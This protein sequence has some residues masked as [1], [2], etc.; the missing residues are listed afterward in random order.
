MHV[1]VNDVPDWSVGQR[2][3]VIN[4]FGADFC[5]T[6]RVDHRDRLVANDETRVANVATVTWRVNRVRTLVNEYAWSDLLRFCILRFC[7]LRFCP[8]RF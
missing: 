1:R 2:A 4:Q 6:T 5:R 8:L 7:L 3:D